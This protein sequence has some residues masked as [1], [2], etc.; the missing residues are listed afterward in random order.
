MALASM[1]PWIFLALTAVAVVWLLSARLKPDARRQASM[2]K[3]ALFLAA[4]DWVFETTGLL[5]GYWHSS[6]SVFALGPSPFYPPLEVFVIALCAGAA[7]DLLFPKKFEWRTALPACMA[8]AVVGTL[9][10]ALLV[11]TG[12]L[13]YLSGWTSFHA[14]VAYWAAF[15]LFHWVD[16]GF[17]QKARPAGS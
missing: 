7:L 10:E 4:F 11:G 3:M 1:S 14:F 2:L 5:L 16:A 12:S 6:G 17:F 8:V 15:L 9:T 13:V